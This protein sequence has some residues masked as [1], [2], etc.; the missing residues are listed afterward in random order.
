M[1]PAACAA[2]QSRAKVRERPDES[3]CTGCPEAITLAADALEA[4]VIERLKRA[5]A[6]TREAAERAVYEGKA[7]PKRA[8]SKRQAKKREKAGRA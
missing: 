7:T 8:E 1:T 2:Y 3:P 5:P 6:T 4:A